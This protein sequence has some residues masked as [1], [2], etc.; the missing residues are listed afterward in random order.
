M[1][2]RENVPNVVLDVPYLLLPCWVM[3][4]H[5]RLRTAWVWQVI[6]LRCLSW[7]MHSVRPAGVRQEMPC[8]SWKSGG[9][10]FSETCKDEKL[11]S[12]GA[13]VQPR[14]LVTKAWQAG[15]LMSGISAIHAT[16]LALS[17]GLLPVVTDVHTISGIA[18]EIPK[19]CTWLRKSKKV[20]LCPSPLTWPQRT[21]PSLR[22]A[23]KAKKSGRAVCQRQC[24]PCDFYESLPEGN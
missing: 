13:H 9:N 11:F 10:S 5:M 17:S 1:W 23:T 4:P 3:W 2:C 24:F 7:Q 8:P 20:S 14:H 21:I 18:A 19:S 22:A 16:E 12:Q 6:W 15:W